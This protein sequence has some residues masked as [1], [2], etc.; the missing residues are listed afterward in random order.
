MSLKTSYK[1]ICEC[2]HEGEII[3]KENDQ[4]FSSNWEHYS[5]V[6]L[7]GLPFSTTES[8]SWDEVLK[9]TGASCPQCKRQIKVEQIK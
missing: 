1:I 2:G 7:S 6:N 3:L 9:Q 4:P 8:A 5:L